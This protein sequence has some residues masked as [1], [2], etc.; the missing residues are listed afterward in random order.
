MLENLRKMLEIGDLSYCHVGFCWR[1]YKQVSLK[2]LV[3][4]AELLQVDGC[5]IGGSLIVNGADFQEIE[6]T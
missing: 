4:S 1:V 6:L 2:W 5:R 3:F